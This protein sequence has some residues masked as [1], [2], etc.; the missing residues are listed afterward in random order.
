MIFCPVITDT[1]QSHLAYYFGFNF[2]IDKRM[3]R[4]RQIRKYY[5]R[6]CLDQIQVLHLHLKEQGKSQNTQYNWYPS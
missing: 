3:T 4:E 1:P 2:I 5:K 6:G